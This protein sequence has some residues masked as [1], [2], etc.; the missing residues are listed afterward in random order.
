MDEPQLSLESGL[1]TLD[2][3]AIIGYLLLTFGIAVWFGSRQKNTED[4]FVGGRSMPW[5]AVGLSIL[6]TLFSTLS[7]LGMPGEAIKNGFGVALGILASPLSMA[8]VM[9]L[10]IPFFMRL[11]LTS[12]YEYLERRYNYAVRLIGAGLFILL[13]LGWMSMV[14]FAASLALDRVKGPDLDW[15]P[16]PDLYWW[17]GLIGVVAAVYTAVGGI[18]AMIWTDVLQC[19]LLLIGI[20]LTIGYVMI[21]D[22]TGPMDWWRTAALTEGR[23]NLPPLFSLDPT[24]RVT[25]VLAI[26]NNFFWTICTHGS[27]QVVLQ[28]YFSTSSL[29]AARKSYL[30]NFCVDLTMLTLLAVCGMALLAFYLKHPALTP[31]GA[32]PVEAADKLFPYFLGNQLPAGFA[33]LIISAFLC[34]AIQTLE[35]GANAISAVAANDLVPR[36]R[37]GGKRVLSELTF[38]RLLSLVIA[39]LVT[40]NAYLVANRFH[41]MGETIVGLMPKFFNMFVGPLSSLFIIGMFFPRCTARSAIPAVICS[42]TLSV[43]W[44]WW[45]EVGYGVMAVANL[46]G[47]NLSSEWEA[48]FAKPPTFLLAIALP[49]VTS[50]S[51]AWLL[52]RVI[53]RGGDH[54]GL[55]YTWKAIVARPEISAQ[56]KS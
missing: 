1:E 22:G 33:G 7:Y 28:R 51:L 5:F 25:I 38:A 2:F 21:V 23:N 16:G 9:F 6:A 54:P 44:S 26:V 24:V 19:L 41:V 27:D 48:W 46:L 49:C 31:D 30:V 47:V 34:D 18:E 13:R 17:I 37:R 20:F 39:L 42:F 32:N 8:V 29:K 11:R 40:A 14:I 50:L 53:E 45:V 35:S 56:V 15:L 10:W 3:V 12:A 52:S 4:F 43:V 36:L 55:A